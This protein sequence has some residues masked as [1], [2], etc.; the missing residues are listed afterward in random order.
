MPPDF[1]VP[2]GTKNTV[3]LDQTD[4]HALVQ[5]MSLA[6]KNGY[7]RGFQYEVPGES[8]VIQVLWDPETE[9]H[10]IA[11]DVVTQIGA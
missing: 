7:V 5:F 1:Y 10:Y 6:D 4:L 3:R 11:Q 2:P 8:R 9:S